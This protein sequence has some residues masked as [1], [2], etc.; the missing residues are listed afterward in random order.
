MLIELH[1]NKGQK[2]QTKSKIWKAFSGT[3]RN[4]MPKKAKK[5]Q[6]K[7]K[8]CKL[9]S[10]TARNLGPNKAKKGKLFRELHEIWGQKKPKKASFFASLPFFLG[11]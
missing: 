4:L 9:F 1:E 5:R 11:F 3:A 2:G 7:S 10:G 6:A 8:L